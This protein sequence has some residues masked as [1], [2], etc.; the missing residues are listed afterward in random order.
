MRLF[1]LRVKRQ[2]KLSFLVL[3][4]LCLSGAP[5]SGADP[6]KLVILFMN[7]PH[8]HYDPYEIRG[9][10]GLSG[11]FAKAQTVLIQQ[12]LSASSEGAQSISLMA[13]DLLMGTPY[14]TF[15]KG[16]LGAKL[17]NM[18]NFQAMVVGN[19]EFDYGVD[20]LMKNLKQNLNMPLLSA[21]IA[22][23][24]GMYP[25]PR[26][27]VFRLAGFKSKILLIGLT[28]DKTPLITLPKNLNGLNFQDPISVARE[29]LE[30][31][32]PEDLVIALTHLGVDEDRRLASACPLIDIIIGGHSHTVLPEPLVENGVII[33]Q[34]GAYAEY[35]GKLEVHVDNGKVTQYD[36]K[37]IRLTSDIPGDEPVSAIL[38]VY[39]DKLDKS[40]QTVLG[41]TEVFLDG[42][43]S[44][45][46]S[47]SS[48]NLGKIIAYLMM[49]NTASEAAMINA[50][51]IRGSI[52]PGD[53]TREK[54]DTA[55]PFYNT[56][57]RMK[58][59]GQ[60]LENAIK[61]SRQLEPNSG[62]KLQSYGIKV[63]DTSSGPIVAEVGGK[64]FDVHGKYTVAV[65]DFLAQGGDG[66]SILMENKK[67]ALDSRLVINDLVV[68]FVRSN[69]AITQV[70]LD[71]ILNEENN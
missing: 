34:A 69:Y 15:F 36:G 29:M 59:D 68:E 14:S 25:F 18:M 61:R 62:G 33:C 32:T 49:K 16:E 43:R 31:A 52:P 13:G 40:F 66:Y 6:Q 46:R 64:P 71:S 54:V 65:S 39:R 56:V 51:A 60:E 44:A 9:L 7:D 35:V 10:S 38:R 11:G 30:H 4:I 23:S 27:A 45:V 41:R 24:D 70:L 58:L 1:R 47:D 5:I 21:N 19:H 63:V 42:T 2:V 37:L 22:T 28:T 67:E 12:R 53:I 3:V 57:V 20:N 26:T 50:G 8:A 48:T 17:L 55:L